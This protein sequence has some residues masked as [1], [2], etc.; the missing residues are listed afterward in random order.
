MIYLVATLT[1][2]PGTLPDFID[3]AKTCIAATRE[4]PGCIS[5]DLHQS[6]TDENTLVF[7][8]RWE[9]QKSLDGHFEAPHFKVWREA[10][11]SYFT[12]RKIEIIDVD[13]DKVTIL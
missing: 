11:S 13:A 6:L 12:S 4:E 2:K 3:A 5:Y 8:E 7:V 10:G 1:I 9:D